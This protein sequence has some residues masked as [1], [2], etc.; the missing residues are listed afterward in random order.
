[1]SD[2]AGRYT[3]VAIGLHW[4]IAA[5]IFVL[6]A[7]GL[8]MTQLKLP[9]STMFRLYQLHKSVG[10]TVLLAVLARVA[11][12][13]GHPPPPLPAGLPAYERRAAGGTHLLLYVLMLF[14]P[15]TGWAMVSASPFNIPTVLFGVV[16]WPH[17]PVVSTLAHK[18][19]VEAAFKAIHTYAAWALIA[20]LALHTGAALR[21]HFV[22]RDG[23]LARMLP[24]V[25]RAVSRR[26][27]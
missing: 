5:G 20:L 25:S 10:I 16:P 8:A 13:L 11:W 1:M 21:H 17:L 9:A 19:P 22:L 4:L 14:L 12:R 27:P 26:A 7:L 23:V 24:T 18:A 2:A 15:L 3:R 6:I